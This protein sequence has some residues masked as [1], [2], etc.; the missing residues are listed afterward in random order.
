MATIQ[1]TE[2]REEIQSIDSQQPSRLGLV[3][4]RTGRTRS[5]LGRDDGVIYTP[6]ALVNFCDRRGSGLKRGSAIPAE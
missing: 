5:Q 2:R 3:V 6:E 4:G 1:P